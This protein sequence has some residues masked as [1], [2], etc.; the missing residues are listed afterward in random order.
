MIYQ[1]GPF[2]LDMATVELREGDKM[3]IPLIVNADSTRS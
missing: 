2:E 3:R 1:F